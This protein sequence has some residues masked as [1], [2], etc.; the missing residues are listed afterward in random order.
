MATDR[1]VFYGGAA[2]GG[3]SEALLMAALQYIEEPGY[4]AILFRRTFADLALPGALM[5]RSREWFGG[6]KA[7][8]NNSEH[9]WTFPS[10]ASLTFGYL[11]H[12]QDKFR[13]QS[14]EFQ[15]VGFDELTQFSESQYRYLFSRLRRLTSS[16]VPLRMRSASNP[17][18]IGHEWVKQRFLVEDRPFVPARLD[19]N[20]FL[21]R[22]EYAQSLDELDPVTRRQLLMGDWTARHAGALFKREWFEIVDE[23]PVGFQHLRYW[24]LAATERKPGTD[25]DWTVGLLLTKSSAGVYYIMDVQRMR[26][27]PQA[28]SARMKQTA[29]MDGPATHIWIEQEPGASGV[30]VIHH[31]VTNVLD[32]FTVRGNR[33]TGSKVERASPVSSQAEAGNVK[34]VQG[35]WVGVFLDEVEAF[36][37]DGTHSHDDQID[38]L[39]GAFMKLRGMIPPP[40]VHDVLGRTQR[41][42]AYNPLGLDLDDPKYTDQ[43]R[44]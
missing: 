14:A 30:H 23:A 34:I 26:G 21:D 3:K 12:E 5:D 41:R 2:G 16:D 40:Q 43:D 6:T 24:D 39:S 37:P 38:A 4:A 10:G 17:G 11:E 28:V 29:Q 15:F 42:D 36:N 13:Y 31:F 18:G 20:P 35:P 33:V 8:W 32:G 1:E 7:R 27:T 22:E 25:P 9:T 44:R 19:D